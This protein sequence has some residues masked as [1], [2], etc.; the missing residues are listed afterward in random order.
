[1]LAALSGRLFL[2]RH[3]YLHDRA[4]T[5]VDAE[6]QVQQAVPRILRYEKVDL[7]KADETW[8]EAREYDLGR[9]A[10]ERRGYGPERRCA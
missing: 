1:M 3:G 2:A 7:V 10:V 8:G 4:G 9:L 6:A 5:A